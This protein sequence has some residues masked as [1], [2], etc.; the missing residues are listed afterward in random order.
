MA[1]PRAAQT[2]NSTEVLPPNENAPQPK[3]PAQ[4]GARDEDSIGT[5]VLLED[6]GH[7]Q[8]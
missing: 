5:E 7:G 4:N 1:G 3:A 2:E 6:I 8:Q